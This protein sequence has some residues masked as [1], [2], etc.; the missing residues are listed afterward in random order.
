MVAAGPFS[1]GST[2][3]VKNTGGISDRYSITSSATGVLITSGQYATKLEVKEKLGTPRVE[4]FMRKNNASHEPLIGG[5]F[6]IVGDSITEGTKTNMFDIEPWAAMVRNVFNKKYNTN[7]IGFI[8]VREHGA[9]ITN[10]HKQTR[11]G[12]AFPVF[13]AGLFGGTLSS[14]TAI[15]D[16]ISWTYYG[17]SAQ[18]VYDKL[19]GNG[20]FEVR[21]D[22]TLVD[23]INCDGP[24]DRGV[25]STRYNT[26]NFGFK[27]HTLEVKNIT[28]ALV[29]IMGVIYSD[30]YDDSEPRVMNVGRSSLRGGDL[31]N[32]MI[33]KYSTSGAL[34]VALGVNDS[35]GS[36]SVSAYETNM[37]RL[38]QN[39]KDVNGQMLFLDFIFNESVSTNIYKQALRR[40]AADFSN[41]SIIDFAD[42]WF[43]NEAINES[44]DLV[45]DDGVHPTPHGHRLIAD[46]VFK[47]LGYGTTEGLPEYNNNLAL[48]SGSTRHNYS[49]NH[50]TY[51]LDS[52]NPIPANTRAG[53]LLKDVVSTDI[54]EQ[55]KWL[56]S[57]SVRVT[58]EILIGGVWYDSGW[59][60][61]NGVAYGAKAS[62]TGNISPVSTSGGIGDTIVYRTANDGV[63][64]MF[65]ALSGGTYPS[66]AANL[67]SAPIRLVL[68]KSD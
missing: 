66:Q 41:A 67:A 8:N 40:V 19:P 26:T 32:N 49:P 52:G 46:A 15:G 21:L 27:V 42:E 25:F 44:F 30:G 14:S 68:T 16:T 3:D 9:G 10:F 31:T 35:L 13:N 1:F 37:R 28:A 23:T 53:L 55:A 11:V 63:A 33:D 43:A 57:K 6:Y 20:T 56:N 5:L 47:W 54:K 38:A 45:A 34:I 4:N 61:D 36:T 59:Y 62:L 29:N 7:N 60:N 24:E 17:R 50:A 65:P 48:I 51:L 39:N 58:A 18:V 64:H 12:F 2:I 22:G